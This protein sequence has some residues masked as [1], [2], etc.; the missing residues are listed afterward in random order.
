MPATVHIDLTGKGAAMTPGC[1]PSH[2][3][4]P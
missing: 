4:K 3:A 2:A 1:G